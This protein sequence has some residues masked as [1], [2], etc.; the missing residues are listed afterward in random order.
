MEKTEEI[1]NEIR[2]FKRSLDLNNYGLFIEYGSFYRFEKKYINDIDINFLTNNNITTDL[3]IEIMGK[4]KNDNKI[5]MLVLNCGKV[6][7]KD[8]YDLSY[9]KKLYDKK[10]INKYDFE[11]IELGIKNKLNEKFLQKLIDDILELKWTY[12][13][14]LK[15]YLI[16]DNIEYKFDNTIINNFIWFDF[17]YTFKENNYL[18]EFIVMP[19]YKFN[20]KK[21]KEIYRGCVLA[22]NEININNYYNFVKR[23]KSCY[24]VMMKRKLYKYSDYYYIKSTFEKVKKYL[25]KNEKNISI[26]HKLLA[27]FKLKKNN[28]SIYKLMNNFNSKFKNFAE[29]YYEEGVEKKLIY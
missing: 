3:I 14:I 6:N 12:E 15:G 25:A 13:D 18:I 7:V 10:L 29:K 23:L 22:L 2:Y 17:I 9:F 11:R 26:Y 27:D 20:S 5:K 19:K 21:T 1:V 8:I 16:F 28:E 4:L 24:A